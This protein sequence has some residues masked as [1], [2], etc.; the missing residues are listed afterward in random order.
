MQTDLSLDVNVTVYKIWTI[1][2]QGAILL[3]NQTL[4]KKTV[5]KEKSHSRNLHHPD[6]DIP[7]SLRYSVLM[8]S[9]GLFQPSYDA[10]SG[11][12]AGVKKSWDK[13]SATGVIAVFSI[14]S[15]IE[16]ARKNT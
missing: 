5:C 6:G 10:V 8:F 3:A 12:K 14:N 7:I 2:E 11:H 4:R 1:A 9:Y 15:D 16:R 13:S